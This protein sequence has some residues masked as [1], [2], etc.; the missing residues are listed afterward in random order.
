M[1]FYWVMCDVLVCVNHHSIWYRSQQ[2]GKQSPNGEKYSM[3]LKGHLLKHSAAHSCRLEVT[4][5]SI[6]CTSSSFVCRICHIGE[7]SEMGYLG[8]PQ[9]APHIIINSESCISF[10]SWEGVKRRA[11]GFQG[12]CC[13]VDTSSYASVVP[14]THTR[15]SH[16]RQYWQYNRTTGTTSSG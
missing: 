4:L 14:S 9:E 5:C 15:A 8:F 2:C 12:Y 13:H 1:I 10:M 3:W 6:D 11:S 16:C 7:L